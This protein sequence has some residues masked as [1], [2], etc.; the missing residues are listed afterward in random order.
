M[1]L[2]HRYALSIFSV[3]G[4]CIAI[5]LVDSLA[6]TQK[7]LGERAEARAEALASAVAGEIIDPLQAGDDKTVLNRIRLFSEVKGVEQIQITDMNG[8]VTHGAGRR[9][10]HPDEQALHRIGRELFAGPRGEARTVEVAISADGIKRAIIPLLV[11]GALWG[12]FSLVIL[13]VASWFLGKRAGRKIEELIAAVSRIEDSTSI[14]LP[15]I[16][17]NSEIGALSRA[18][19][20]LHRRLKA[21]AARRKLLEEQRD[22]MVN[23]LVHDLKHPLTIFRMAI[24]AFGE[25]APGGR[26][27]E[28]ANTLSMAARGTA[29]MEAMIDGILQT[30]NLER[31]P[32]PPPRL[33]TPVTAFLRNCAEEDALIVESSKRKWSLSVDPALKN[34]WI[35]ANT[36]MLRRLI[37][38]LVLN[39]I[40]HAPDGTE[41]T[42]GAKLKDESGESVEL[43]V[44]NDASPFQLDSKSLLHGKYRSST[45]SS[46]AGLGLE[47]CRLAAKF[48]SGQFHAAQESDGHVVFSLLIPLGKDHTPGTPPSS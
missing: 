19:Q 23:M 6:G 41:V 29:R 27:R 30:A 45:G 25:C 39:A 40:E 8:R 43:F 10:G 42:L 9:I 4:L 13:G 14:D 44:S 3:G 1:K 24:S 36:P 12:G 35:W 47:F 46:H 32:E 37:G 48:H 16:D 2:R 22:D 21:E 15:D 28:F 33:R 5:M 11:R 7:L 38:N 18:F 31:A 26:S 20:E 17:R 34:R